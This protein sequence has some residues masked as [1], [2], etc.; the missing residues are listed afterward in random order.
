MAYN[1]PSLHSIEL[2][3][4]DGITWTGAMNLA[5]LLLHN[6][7]ITHVDVRHTNIESN[8]AEMLFGQCRKN[9]RALFAQHKKNPKLSAHPTAIHLRAMKRYFHDAQH[10]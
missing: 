2:Y 8:V 4:N 7:N 9:A 6:V 3:D 10:E 1:H 5:N